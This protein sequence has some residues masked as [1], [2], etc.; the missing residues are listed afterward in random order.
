MWE[1]FKNNIHLLFLPPHTS[2]V[3]QPLD[4]LVFSPLKGAYRK[5]LGTLALLN[6]STPVGKR[7]FLECYKL[8]RIDALTPT[9]CMQGWKALGLWPPRMSK[10]LMNRL[11]LE[12][13]NKAAEETPATSGNVEVPEWNQ[14]GSFILWETPRKSEDVRQQARQIMGLE[15]ADTTTARVLF[16]KVAKGLD[17]KDFLIAQHER[18]IQQLEARVQ[19]LEPRKRRKVRTSPNSKF[20]SIEDIYRAQVADGERE[21]I[22]VDSDG[23]TSIASTLSHITINE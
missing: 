3:L 10:P 1:C 11:L 20:A 12:N 7:N 16:R 13:S 14:D 6:D 9:N 19:Q 17:E 23:P 8:A 2:H 4:L 21:S 15:Q 18:R 22:P 5:R